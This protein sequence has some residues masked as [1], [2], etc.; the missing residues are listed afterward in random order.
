MSRYPNHGNAALHAII[1]E[2]GPD[3]RDKARAAELWQSVQGT[4]LEATYRQISQE[5]GRKNDNA[6]LYARFLTA[7]EA[8]FVADPAP[9]TTIPFPSPD[10]ARPERVPVND[11]EASSAPTPAPEHAVT[12]DAP[13]AP[14]PHP[15]SV[16]A[17]AGAADAAQDVPP[18]GPPLPPAPLAAPV[19]GS[20]F[21]HLASMVPPGGQTTL[22][23]FRLP[24]DQVVVKVSTEDGHGIRG[25]SLT[26][27]NTP[28]Y[29]DEHLLPAM[30]LYADSQ[31]D[32]YTA[33]M[34]ARQAQVSK[35]AAAQA[36]AASKAAPATSTR[37]SAPRTSKTKTHQVTLH[38]A[39]GT[40]LTAA[41]N[42]KP[43][44]VTT[45]TQAVPQGNLELSWTH[46]LYGAGKKTLAV[47]GDKEHDF[48]DAQGGR[49]AVITSPASAAVTARQG[50]HCLPLHGE[51]L[52]PPGT[53]EIHADAADH[54]PVT[55][56]V[57]VKAGQGQEI[58]LTLAPVQ[59]P[60]LF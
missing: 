60:A 31:R 55:Q 20:L 43:L 8:L 29:F 42:G 17:D 12:D 27:T 24:D 50:A 14:P 34:E 38:A 13:A 45:G 32:L 39:D 18:A 4:P 54:D 37:A 25:E 2:P 47:W 48:R 16:P 15:P 22:T 1:T 19:T 57:K 41:S 56:T 21:T 49:L 10:P 7:I 3:P 5:H 40:T 28:A 53:W 6:A 23:V 51:A 11:P 36:E 9:G 46:P 35:K 58:T 26:V 30:P 59:Q 44:P 33:V 52:L